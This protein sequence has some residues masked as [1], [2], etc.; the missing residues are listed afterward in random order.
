MAQVDNVNDYFSPMLAGVRASKYPLRL[1]MPLQINEGTEYLIAGAFSISSGSFKIM[2]SLNAYH[3]ELS[4]DVNLGVPVMSFIKASDT[5][6]VLQWT[7]QVQ[8]G[9]VKFVLQIGNGL[10]KAYSFGDIVSQ[11]EMTLEQSYEMTMFNSTD[12]NCQSVLKM[13]RVIEG[14]FSDEEVSN[15]ISKGLL[16]ERYSPIPIKDICA[17]DFNL[18][19]LTINRW[20][21]TYK[22]SYL[23]SDVAL[24]IA[25][26]FIGSVEHKPLSGFNPFTSL[27]KPRISNTITYSNKKTG[28]L[29]LGV[30]TIENNMILHKYL[31]SS[32][33]SFAMESVNELNFGVPFTVV[34]Y[35]CPLNNKALFSLG[36]YE[37]KAGSIDGKWHLYII[38]FDGMTIEIID[39]YSLV[40]RETKSAPSGILKVNKGAGSVSFIKVYEG[41]L[42]NSQIQEYNE[43]VYH[44]SPDNNLL[45]DLSDQNLTSLSWIDSVSG[46]GVYTSEPVE[47]VN[48][49]QVYGVGKVSH[50]SPI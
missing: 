18:S 13:L 34:I 25:K 37:F 10:V 43:N 42:T 41:L 6:Q 26:G 28:E 2:Y 20:Y 8:N 36:D 15:L 23:Y 47:V 12:N 33:D 5:N 17:Y 7:N 40:S 22:Q 45:Y 9:V 24:N 44:Y 11:I 16:N 48:A 35:C 39:G 27:H 30:M 29:V 46:L 4:V 38:R 3:L 21:S 1:L 49:P 32:A 50:V 19:T 31:Y 14:S